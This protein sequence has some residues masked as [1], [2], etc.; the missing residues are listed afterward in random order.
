MNYADMKKDI[1]ASIARI[2]NFLDID[3]DSDRI[4]D[5]EKNISMTAMRKAA[6][7]YVPDNGGASWQGGAKTFINKGINGRWKEILSPDEL[8]LYDLACDKV[9]SPD[10]RDWLE[11]GREVS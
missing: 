7:T 10:C 6:K 8:T 9:L 11:N 3:V 5:V 2:A 4:K 1:K